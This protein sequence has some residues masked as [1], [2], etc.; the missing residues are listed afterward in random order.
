MFNKWGKNELILL[1]QSYFPERH[2]D[3]CNNIQIILFDTKLTTNQPFKFW[4]AVTLWRAFSQSNGYSLLCLICKDKRKNTKERN[5][6]PWHGITG[7]LGT[8]LWNAVWHQE[9]LTVLQLSTMETIIIYLNLSNSSLCAW[10][11]TSLCTEF[12]DS[13]WERVR[14]YRNLPQIV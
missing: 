9:I 4:R 6:S 1:N 14:N 8:V 5:R 13:R 3:K 11:G 7:E 10:F 2:F 12:L